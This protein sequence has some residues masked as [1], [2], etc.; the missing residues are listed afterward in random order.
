[1]IETSGRLFLS[2]VLCVC[3]VS[4]PSCHSRLVCMFS[5]R[6]TLIVAPTLMLKK[7]YL[8]FSIKRAR[9]VIDLMKYYL[10]KKK[11]AVAVL[12]MCN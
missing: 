1:M 12:Y 3:Q 10:Q 2:Q 5:G 7:R 4:T 6:Q 8:S 11:T 9:R